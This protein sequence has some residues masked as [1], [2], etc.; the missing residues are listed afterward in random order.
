[1]KRNI[2]KRTICGLLCTLLLTLSFSFSALASVRSSVMTPISV[3]LDG[4]DVFNYHSE[5]KAVLKD[6][7]TY[8]P[9]RSFCDLMGGEVKWEE[10]TR[11]A[12]VTALSIDL[13][14]SEGAQYII[15]NDRALYCPGGIFITDGALYVPVR[16]LAKAF[17]LEVE[18]RADENIGYVELTSGGAR[19]EHASD[20]YDAEV[21]YWL[22]RIISAESR[23]E[24]LIGQIAVG[25]VVLNR[26]RSE[27]FPDTVY[28]V[29]FDRKFGVQFTPSANGTIYEKP[30]EISV[31]AAK[32][33]LEGYTISDKILYFLNEAISTNM[34]VTNNRTYIMT[35][36]NHAFYS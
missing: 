31:I 32:I 11:T 21:L 23:G 30:A 10:K 34:W 24:N 5:N 28:D 36:G 16:V 22:S 4:K 15:V 7:V 13:S 6:S 35:L 3:K 14:A 20:V 26:T 8:V 29:I 17:G 25:N 1:M 27:S 9:L 33:C 2:L 12:R 18:W 19:L